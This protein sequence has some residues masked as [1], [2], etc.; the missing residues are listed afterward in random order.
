MKKL[1]YIPLD[2]HLHSENGVFDSILNGF[3]TE[4][5]T[6]IFKTLEESIRFNPDYVF[7]HGNVISLEDCNTLKSLTGAMF[8]IWVGDVRY[9][10][11]PEAMNMIGVADL[12]LFPFNGK[13][14]EY[15]SRILDT[16]CEYIFEVFDD[17][18][19]REVKEMTVGR[20]VFVGNVYDHFPGGEERISLAN[21]IGK[22][23]P[24]LE[25]YGSF[26]YSANSKGNI[27]FSQ[28]PDLYNTSYLTI[29][30]NNRNDIDGYFTHR[31]LIALASGSCVLMKH[32]PGIEQFFTNWEHCVFY[33][34]NYELLD[35]IEFLKREPSIRNKIAKNGNSYVRQNYLN[36]NFAHN[37]YQILK[38]KYLILNS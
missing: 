28:V 35:I 25:L 3:K 18:Q 13:Q 15:F 36:S 4:F 26:P 10:P 7:M 12:Y 20:V 33:K 34:T 21:F 11:L 30:H 16:P 17:R 37:F 6:L 8:T 31:N 38:N 9:A 5:N 32:F 19:V 23:V 14:L 22:Y 1:L 29:A 27:D 2:Y 24:E